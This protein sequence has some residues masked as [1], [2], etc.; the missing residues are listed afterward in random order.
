MRLKDIRGN[1]RYKNVRKK[2]IDWD[3]K[4]RS[5]FQ[6]EVKS[7]L[8]SF[9]YGDVVFEEFPVY[10]TRYTLDFYNARRNIAI[11]VQGKQHTRYIKHFHNQNRQNFIDQLKKDDVKRQFCEINN[12]ELIEIMEEERKKLNLEFIGDLLDADF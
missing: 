4:S 9:W 1:S 12:I 11:E 8:R 6:E 5:K 3:G 7:L 10:G 2:A